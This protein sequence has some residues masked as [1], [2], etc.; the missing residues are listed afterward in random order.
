MEAIRRLE[1]LR[2][3]LN[4]LLRRLTEAG[5]SIDLH[6]HSPLVEEDGELRNP[7]PQ[8]DVRVYHVLVDTT[9]TGSQPV[10]QDPL[11]DN[12]DSTSEE[13]EE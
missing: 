5:F 3:E 8:L 11:D 1:V 13:T 9:K 10:L 6:S 12:W 2:D 4:D 7:F